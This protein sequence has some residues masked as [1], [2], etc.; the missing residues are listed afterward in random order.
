MYQPMI[1]VHDHKETDRNSQSKPFS[2]DG[3]NDTDIPYSLR[4]GLKEDAPKS[5]RW[6]PGKVGIIC[7]PCLQGSEIP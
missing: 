3:I 6:S 5:Q 2:G 7:S 4:Q 1:L